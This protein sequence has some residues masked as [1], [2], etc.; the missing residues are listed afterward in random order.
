MKT[1][2]LGSFFPSSLMC[3]MCFVLILTTS[4]CAHPLVVP[5]SFS[6]DDLK[7]ENREDL[8]ESLIGESQKSVIEKIGPPN[9][10][11]TDRNQKYMI[12]EHHSTAN[13]MLM[14][15]AFWPVGY[16]ESDDNNDTLHCLKI[17]LDANNLV[18]DYQ[19]KSTAYFETG[20]FKC[21]KEYWKE[22]EWQ[23]FEELPVP[24]L[25]VLRDASNLAG[26]NR[27]Y[28]N[29]MRE[30]YILAIRKKVERN[31]RKPSGDLNM[32]ICEVHV[33]QGPG[34]IILDVSFG[35]C[36]GSSARYRASIENAV[37]KAEPLPKLGAPALFEQ[38]LTFM[39]NPN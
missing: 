19:F 36:R 37:Y 16:L 17:D 1:K 20:L 13:E 27:R 4:G 2:L 39:F 29:P 34:G 21:P 9:Q 7:T 24:S 6:R 12:Y 38:E 5:V 35:A 30:A 8:A 3:S 32:P 23:S 26:E 28:E 10:I 33:V 14:L 11:L 18:V 22:G 25:E 31:W 15:F